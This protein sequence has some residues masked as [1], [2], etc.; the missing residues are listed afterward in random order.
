MMN[1]V[2]ITNKQELRKHVQKCLLTQQKHAVMIKNKDI[3]EQFFALPV[4]NKAKT[5]LFY[6]A[7]KGE[8]DTFNMME[9]ALLLG[10]R[11]A[12]PFVKKEERKIIPVVI[13]TTDVLKTGVYGIPEP[14][15][16]EKKA[17]LELNEIDIIVVPGLAFD[18]L[19][20][21]LG[22][23]AGYYD[24][25]IPFLS[26]HTI[27]IGLAYDFQMFKSLPFLQSHDRSVDIVITNRIN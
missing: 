23:G 19:G 16:K 7:F 15:R 21:R 2:K 4:V 26:S 12:V 24:R 5:I 9:R 20:N 27:T 18:F 13:K 17:Q 14:P 1:D 22:R 3:T 6:A 25:L 11:I 10:K 8:V